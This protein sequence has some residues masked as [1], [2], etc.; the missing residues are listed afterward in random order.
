MTVVG[1]VAPGAMGA[2]VGACLRAAGSEVLWASQGRSEQ[3]RRRADAA[4]LRDVG[5]LARLCRDVEVLVSICPPHAAVATAEQ[6]AAAGFQGIYLDANA[7]APATAARI[8]AG[9]AP[10]TYLDG[11]L[12]GGPPRLRRAET[13]D[14]TG[15][16]VLPRNGEADGRASDADA[17]GHRTD[18]GA[19]GRPSD[20][21][22]DADSTITTRLVL[23]GPGD[24]AH[25][26]AGLVDPRRGTL[27]AVVLDGELTAA[28]ALKLAFAAWTKG[29]S[30][31]LLAVRAY[32]QAAGVEA[33]LLD[34]WQWA[35][36][37]LEDR[38]QRTAPGIA[39]KAWRWV[40]EMQEIAAA[41]A[42]AGLPDDLHVGAA[43]VYARLA[44][45]HGEAPADVATVLAELVREPDAE[46]RSDEGS[47]RPASPGPGAT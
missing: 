31:L 20:A 26:V 19:E 12:I 21:G 17:G 3:T 39:D 18:A 23:S 30:A 11:G 10:A 41:F 44:H 28:S 7:I 35:L 45:R 38:V 37:D 14:G 16:G 5:D 33:A 8:S 40:A 36:P 24:P 27:A 29:S 32:A 1:L 4:G 22:A 46:P 42:A 2:A 43:E 47:R 34:T 13:G 15:D 9:V 6:V 25:T